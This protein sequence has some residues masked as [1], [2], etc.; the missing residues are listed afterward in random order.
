MTAGRGTKGAAPDARA[1]A[2]GALL[3]DLAVM[4]VLIAFYIPYAGAALAT[5]SPIPLLLLILR[6]GWRV[7]VESA[8]VACLLVSFL[9]G[10]F[11]AST[12]V[13]FSLRAA[14]LAIGLRRGWRVGRTIWVGTTF[15]WLVV[16]AGVTAAALAIPA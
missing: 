4:T 14:A 3:A 8:V 13:I 5:V 16:C 6:R 11:S 2:E 7:G 15:L 12:V 1:I 10:P 9:T